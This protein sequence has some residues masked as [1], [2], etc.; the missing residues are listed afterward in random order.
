MSLIIDTVRQHIPYRHK[1]TPSGWHS[2]NAV[3]CHHNGTGQD[4]RQRG[5]IIFNADSVSYHCFN[6][7]FKT[8]W[9]PGRPLTAKFKKFLHWLNVSDDLISKC[10]LE[11]LKLK[12]E[13]EKHTYTTST[14]QFLA[15]ELPQLSMTLKDWADVMQGEIEQELGEQY[16]SIIDYVINRG[17]SDPFDWDFYWSP[18]YADRIIIPFRYQGQIVGYTARRITDHKPKYIS[19]QQPGYVFNLDNQ[20]YQRKFV[21]VCEGPF[22]AIGIDGV[23]ILGSELSPQQIQLIKKLDREVIVVP[24]KDHE[25]PKIIKQAIENDWTVSFPDWQLCKD[26]NEAVVK[27][28]RLKTLHMI[29][30]STYRTELKIRLHMKQWLKGDLNV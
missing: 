4:T 22:D 5:G 29:L 13:L 24:D 3:C 11:S 16:L 21:I 12:D 17:F 1:S 14:P 26:I 30:T 6:C 28:G 2:F 9:Q 8:S 10:S 18:N 20:N 19:E 7:Q 23:A 15:R 27:Y 25:G